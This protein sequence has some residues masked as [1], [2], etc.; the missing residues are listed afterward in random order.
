M[1]TKI[2]VSTAL[3]FRIKDFE[4]IEESNGLEIEIDVKD[5]KE[6]DKEIEK[7]QE[8]IHKKVIT[9]GFKAANQYLIEKNNII[10]E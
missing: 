6:L 2:K 4:M 3:K 10:N 1:K 9:S 8:Y 5:E 7:W